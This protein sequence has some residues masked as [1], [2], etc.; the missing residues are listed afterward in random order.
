MRKCFRHFKALMRKNLMVWV[1]SW[2][3]S[4]FEIIA[5]IILM[6][7]LCV[8]RTKVPVTPVDQVGMLGKKAPSM[9]GIGPTGMYQWDK[10]TDSSYKID[11]KFKGLACHAQYFTSNAPSDC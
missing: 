3:C 1:R 8:F 7:A 9:I 11:E 2:G 4:T 10:T 6:V 5:P